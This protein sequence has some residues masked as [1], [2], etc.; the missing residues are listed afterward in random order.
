MRCTSELA[1]ENL[2]SV[3]TGKVVRFAQHR[4]TARLF[5]RRLFTA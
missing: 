5:N 3:E 2:V 4:A 1:G